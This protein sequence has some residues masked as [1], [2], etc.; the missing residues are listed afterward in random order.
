MIHVQGNMLMSRGPLLPWTRALSPSNL[1]FLPNPAFSIKWCSRYWVFKVTAPP[2][3]FEE[4]LQRVYPSVRLC[5][6]AWRTGWRIW[7]LLALVGRPSRWDARARYVPDEEDSRA[8]KT[9]AFPPWSEKH[10]RVRENR[11]C[12]G[13][14]FVRSPHF[15]CITEELQH[16]NLWQV[17]YIWRNCWLP[18]NTGLGLS[19]WQTHFHLAPGTAAC[20]AVPHTF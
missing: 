16:Y 11:G 20:R 3:T 7:F 13:V 10:F 2:F 17:T 1:I 19:E 4:L 12:W 8:W 14:V 15:S 18:I 5:P 9:Q 6:T